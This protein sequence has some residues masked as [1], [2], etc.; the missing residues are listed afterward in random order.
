MGWGVRAWHPARPGEMGTKE[1]PRPGRE[2]GV[3]S[4]V[5]HGLSR[6]PLPAQAWICSGPGLVSED[7][8]SEAVHSH[9]GSQVLDLPMQQQL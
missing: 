1:Q 2:V 3:H 6:F 4:R 7:D 9:T 8:K 5:G